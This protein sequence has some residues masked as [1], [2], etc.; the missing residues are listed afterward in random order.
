[1]ETES[2][3]P[4]H[5][6]YNP[7]KIEIQLQCDCGNWIKTDTRRQRVECDCGKFFAVT[8]TDISL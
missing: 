8:V 3:P 1:M 6:E 4:T 5:D 7:D 2:R